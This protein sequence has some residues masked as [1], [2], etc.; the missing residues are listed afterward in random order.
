MTSSKLARAG[1]HLLMTPWQLRAK[2]PRATLE[3]IDR[4][5]RNSESAQ[6]GEICFVVEGALHGS[7]LY[8]GQSARDRA[9]ELFSRL[10]L[11]DTDH[12]N[13]VLIYVLLADRAVE[14]IADRGAHSKVDG[15]EWQGVCRAME[16]AFSEGRYRV[17]TINGIRA[18]TRHLARHFPVSTVSPRELY[19]PIRIT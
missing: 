4:E 9:I 10:R 7:A 18:V 14:I 19:A 17:G 5:I 6:T 12:R 8:R 15:D 3:A 2:F 11:W 13:S 1:R 16:A